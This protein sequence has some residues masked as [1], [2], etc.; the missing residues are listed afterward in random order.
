[1]L[2]TEDVSFLKDLI[3]EKRSHYPNQVDAP[4][5][6]LWKVCLPVD[7]ITPELTVDDVEGSEELHPVK[8]ISSVFGEG[9]V[10]D[11]VHI[12]VQTHI[13]TLYKRDLGLS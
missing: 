6:T 9:L 2:K 11:H 7:V 3:K 13:G 1:M 12:L 4:E 8:R 10:D 5:L